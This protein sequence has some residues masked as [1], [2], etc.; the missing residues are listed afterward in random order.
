MNNVVVHVVHGAEG[1]SKLYTSGMYPHGRELYTEGVPT[2][3][4][5]SM[6]DLLNCI[7]TI[8]GEFGAI[9]YI[10]VGEMVLVFTPLE[11]L[12]PEMVACDEHASCLM[13]IPIESPSVPQEPL[14]SME[15]CPVCLEPDKV[16]SKINPLRF[17]AEQP[18]KMLWCENGHAICIDCV[19][20]CSLKRCACASIRCSAMVFKCP[21]CRT[22]TQLT[23]PEQDVLLWGS[24]YHA[25]QNTTYSVSL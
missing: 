17:S 19:R 15:P 8:H 14:P 1:T 16:C 9:T 5:D 24:W 12:P 21:C 23:P 13:I 20:G 11:V 10:Q 2:E 22:I 3:D 6:C 7:A 18:G 4:V 25:R